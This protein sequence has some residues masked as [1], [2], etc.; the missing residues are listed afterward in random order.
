MIQTRVLPLFI[1]VLPLF[2]QNWA[3]FQ[4][5]TVT[6]QIEAEDHAGIQTYQML[7]KEQGFTGIEDWVQNCCLAVAT[8]LYFTV[9]EANDQG[10]RE[11]IY[12]LNDG[13]PLSY[14]D[15]AVP[16]IEIGFDLNYLVDFIEKHG[17]DAAR[18]EIYGVLCHEITHGYQ[19]E[20]KNAGGYENDTEFFAFI[21]GSA[22]LVRLKTGGFNPPRFPK[23]S[24]SYLSGYNTTTFF[25][26]WIHNT[27]SQTFIK[28]LNV[29]ADTCRVWTL[30]K[31][32]NL[33][34]NQS[35][36]SLWQQYQKNIEN[37]PWEKSKR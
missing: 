13:G 5:P 18:D 2:A 12:K 8:E 7:I 22:D 19:K 21:E 24:G 32:T 29:T 35:A 36:D 10:L 30:N 3:D 6:V 14:K 23:T 1:F 33:F 37:Y 11:I 16:A 34:L 4:Y 26:L 27:K 31:A 15:G 25:Y 17:N 9:D 20:P 28:D